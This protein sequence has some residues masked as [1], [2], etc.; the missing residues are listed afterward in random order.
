MM[1]TREKILECAE[2][3]FGD[4]GYDAVTTKDI[5]KKVGCNEVTLFR[6]FKNKNNILEEIINR[7]IDEKG[8]LKIFY[9]SLTGELE[10]DISKVIFLYEDFLKSHE[11][12]FK[13]QLKLSDVDIPKFMRTMEIKS[14]LIEHFKQC[15]LK[16]G[17]E[18]S[19]EIFVTDILESIL[20]KALLR[21]VLKEEEGRMRELFFLNEKIKFYQTA[22]FQYKMKK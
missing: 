7:S 16:E 17:I 15:F 19:A 21:I 18:Y 9:E 12:L 8:I 20:G 13:L 1:R 4:I 6:I 2:N 14:Y 5:A 22:I 3:L 10:G 11:H